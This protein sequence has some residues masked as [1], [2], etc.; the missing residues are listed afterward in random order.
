MSKRYSPET[1]KHLQENSLTADLPK[2]ENKEQALSRLH[3]L[4]AEY[5]EAQAKADAL[6]DTMR[7][8]TEGFGDE[9]KLTEAQAAELERFDLSVPV[10][11]RLSDS[12]VNAL[13]YFEGL[14]PKLDVAKALPYLERHHKDLLDQLTTR[15]LNVEA[16][17]SAVQAGKLPSKTTATMYKAPAPKARFKVS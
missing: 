9:E 8:L 2:I 1:V 10:K 15:V 14:S 4:V 6:H 12:L 13:V 5:K 3:Q 11:Y 16:F 7:I 17:E